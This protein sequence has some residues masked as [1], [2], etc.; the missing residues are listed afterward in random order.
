MRRE[1][2]FRNAMIYD[3]QLFLEHR[4]PQLVAMITL[5]FTSNNDDI[6][7]KLYQSVTSAS[8]FGVI[9]KTPLH[10][11][12]HEQ[13]SSSTVVCAP[14]RLKQIRLEHSCLLPCDTRRPKSSDWTTKMHLDKTRITSSRS[15]GYERDCYDTALDDWFT[16]DENDYLDT[17]LELFNLAKRHRDARDSAPKGAYQEN[18]VQQLAAGPLDI[19]RGFWHLEL[20]MLDEEFTGFLDKV[21]FVLL[22]GD[23]N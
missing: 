1:K 13:F 23:V 21:R 17:A 11:E 20:R 10:H 15:T 5:P 16:G 22:Q 14:K 3:E 6:D 8:I 7:L 12:T 9:L 18:H 2:L 19:W 4:Y